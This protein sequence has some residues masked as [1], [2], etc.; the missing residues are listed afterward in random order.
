MPESGSGVCHELWAAALDEVAGFGDDIRQHF[1]HFSDAGFAI[2]NLIEL[3]SL[4]AR[5]FS[6]A[7][8][9]TATSKTRETPS[10]QP[11]HAIPAGDGSVEY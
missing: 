2:N 7:R 1:D 10:Q 11:L 3:L 8:E 4:G 6:P 5:S 9:S